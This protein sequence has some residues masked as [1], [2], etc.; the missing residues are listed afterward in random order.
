[1]IQIHIKL[2]S[3]GA[4]PRGNLFVYAI[5]CNNL[6]YVEKKN[7]GGSLQSGTGNRERPN[8]ITRRNK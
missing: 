1:V 8:N 4:I 7:T 6:F 5:M 3:H 2:I